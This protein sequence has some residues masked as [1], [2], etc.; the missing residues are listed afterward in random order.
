[1]A[2]A[3]M[4]P[5]R[6]LDVVL[7]S[8]RLLLEDPRMA[9]A[10][11]A[12]ALGGEKAAASLQQAAALIVQLSTYGMSVATLVQL[13]LGRPAGVEGAAGNTKNPCL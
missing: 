13:A 7:Q 11:A 10:S 9:V 5:Q 3:L 6:I 12:A 8:A 2:T 1:M 4:P